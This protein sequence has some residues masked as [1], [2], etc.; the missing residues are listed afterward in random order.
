[1]INDNTIVLKHLIKHAIIF[2]KNIY[3]RFSIEG[4]DLSDLVIY[5]C[6]RGPVENLTYAT[7]S[8]IQ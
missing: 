1:M 8:Y 7:D 2:K 3:K 6:M 5:V 4:R